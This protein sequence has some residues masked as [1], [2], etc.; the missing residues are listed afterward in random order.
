ME[1]SNI[2]QDLKNKA[3]VLEYIKQLSVT[4]LIGLRIAQEILKSS[5][6]IEE[7]IGFIEWCTKRHQP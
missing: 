2:E 5:F 7:S 1:D 6:S 4:D 3:L